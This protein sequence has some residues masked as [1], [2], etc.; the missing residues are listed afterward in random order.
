AAVQKAGDVIVIELLGRRASADKPAVHVELVGIVCPDG[1]AALN[2]VGQFEHFPEM[3]GADRHAVR[4]MLGGPNPLSFLTGRCPWCKPHQTAKQ[5]G[6]K[7]R[8]GYGQARRQ[9]CVALHD[10]S[11]CRKAARGGK[12]T[13]E[14]CR[15]AT[16]ILLDPRSG[17]QIRGKTPRNGV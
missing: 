3:T 7:D 10:R 8:S 12:S 5:P 15:K 11:Q 2:R 9:L 16:A 4:T 6:S 17:Q 14:A 1:N 13:S